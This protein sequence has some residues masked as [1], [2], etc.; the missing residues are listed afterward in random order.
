MT[1][2]SRQN[3]SYIANTK[4]QYMA[5][6]FKK[7]SFHH[8]IFFL[9][10]IPAANPGISSKLAYLIV[11]AGPVHGYPRLVGLQDVL[12]S[13]GGHVDHNKADMPE[14]TRVLKPCRGSGFG[15]RSG[16]AGF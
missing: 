13:H 10:C 4:K 11:K 2:Y 9:I 6:S 1:S 16:S 3:V 12:H 8:H 5:L 15:T 14:K 7:C